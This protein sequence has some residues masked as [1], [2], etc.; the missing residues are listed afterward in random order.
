MRHRILLGLCALI[1]PLALLAGCVG[2]GAGGDYPACIMVDGAVYRSTGQVLVGEVDESAVL[3]Q[4]SS[5]TDGV[6]AEEG[7]ANF[8]RSL[9]ARYART[10][11]GLLVC[12]DGEWTLFQ[13]QT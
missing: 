8:D 6:P 7:Q 13:P 11:D 9:S 1:L 12:L 10:A 5:Y 3:G 2:P 4:V